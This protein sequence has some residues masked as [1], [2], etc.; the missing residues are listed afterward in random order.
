METLEAIYT[1]RSI[2]RFKNDP[3]SEENLQHLLR[4]GMQAPSARNTQAWQF[5]VINE[6]VILNEIN[7]FHPFASML[8]EAPLAIAVCGDK[9]AEAHEGYLAVNCAA[10]T[11]NILLAAHAL[12]LGAVWIGI[13]PRE[14]R[15]QRLSELLQLPDFILPVSLVALGYPAEDKQ[16][17]DRYDQAKVHLNRWKDGKEGLE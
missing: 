12:E 9:R 16:A 13:Y 8:S 7:D 5:I 15:I 3:V 4:A 1:R 11:Q 17:I 6:R 2:R 10:A 14:N